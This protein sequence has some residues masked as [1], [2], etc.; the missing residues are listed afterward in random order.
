MKSPDLAPIEVLQA[1]RDRLE[2]VI[3]E[4]EAASIALT[5]WEKVSAA[6]DA[7]KS[8]L[9]PAAMNRVN[10]IGEQA[11]GA[12][13][14]LRN[15]I[16]DAGSWLDAWTS[17]GKRRIADF[18][19]LADRGLADPDEFAIEIEDEPRYLPRPTGKA[20]KA[21]LSAEQRALLASVDEASA[22]ISAA[23]YPRKDDDD[24]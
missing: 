12:L 13:D 10:G 17:A 8:S 11:I 16:L 24:D 15:V 21:T 18:H 22:S 4:T 6:A 5:G 23:V 19:R 2:R 20:M 14:R 1:E 9:S 3:F 7:E